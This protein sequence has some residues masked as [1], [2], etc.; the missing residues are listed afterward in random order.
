[1]LIEEMDGLCEQIVKTKA[2]IEELRAQIEAKEESIKAITAKVYEYFLE[3]KRT[4]P[5]RSPNGTLYLRSD[6]S[7]LVPRGDNCLQVLEHMRERGEQ[8]YLDHITINSNKLKSY[9]KEYVKELTAEGR[10]PILEPIPGLETPKPTQT[11][12]YKRGI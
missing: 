8:I 6:I 5:Y 10:D 4:A 9:Y 11:L 3:S 1:M 12:I 2:E 7:L